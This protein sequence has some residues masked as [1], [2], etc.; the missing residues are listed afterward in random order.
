[1]AASSTTSTIITG[2][3]VNIVPSTVSW[4]VD[5]GG[6]STASGPQA[7]IMSIETKERLSRC[8][9]IGAR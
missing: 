9:S 2:S 3:S 4:L 8:R 5:I 7:A 6:T 1:V